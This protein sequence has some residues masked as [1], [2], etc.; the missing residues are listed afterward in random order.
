MKNTCI[1]S[2]RD[3]RTLNAL[4]QAV[5]EALDTVKMVGSD[6]EV[7]YVSLDGIGVANFVN[8]SLWENTLTDGSK[9]YDVRVT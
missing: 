2:W 5:S 6:P 8:L 7:V 9:T 3:L 4:K 1:E